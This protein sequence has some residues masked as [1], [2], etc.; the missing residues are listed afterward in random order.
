MGLGTIEITQKKRS[1]HSPTC[2]SVRST[3]G[4]MEYHMSV[5]CYR[6][7]GSDGTTSH[8]TFLLSLLWGYGLFFCFL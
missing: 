3:A 4:K 2:S 6:A 1:Q 5:A 7:A 8:L